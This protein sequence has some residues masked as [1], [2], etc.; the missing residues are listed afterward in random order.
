MHRTRSPVVTHNNRIRT[1]N[2]F[3]RFLSGWYQTINRK[4]VHYSFMISNEPKKARADGLWWSWCD[5]NVFKSWNTL[6]WKFIIRFLVVASVL[7]ITSYSCLQHFLRNAAAALSNT[8]KCSKN[9][10]KPDSSIKFHFHNFNLIFQLAFKRKRNLWILFSP[11]KI[12]IKTE[13]REN[14][15]SSLSERFKVPSSSSRSRTPFFFVSARDEGLSFGC[16]LSSS[17][18]FIAFSSSV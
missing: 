11:Q 9:F 1:K 18:V 12:Q 3:W 10:T 17:S 6:N 5:F 13:M 15:L 14:F 8:Q 2:H 4:H 16:T 7:A